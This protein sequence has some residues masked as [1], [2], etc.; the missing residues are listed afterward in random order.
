MDSFYASVEVRDNPSLK[1][2]PVG[3]G[4][5]TEKRGVLCTANY[6]A[7]KYGVKAALS[8]MYALKLCP[9]LILVKP[10]FEK[11]QEESLKIRE[12][13]K[14]YTELIEPLSLD[15][16]FLDVSDCKKCEGSATLIA[17]EI[18]AKIFDKTKL[19]ASA[20]IA[21]N[22]FLAKVASDWNKPNGQFVITPED[23]AEF[24]YKLPLK[25]IFGVGKV[26]ATKLHD[27]G[28]KTCGDIQKASIRELRDIV[29]S[30]GESLHKYSKGIDDR[31]V[32]TTRERKSI[33]VEHTF[34]ED[35][36]EVKEVAKKVEKIFAEL[37]YRL[38]NKNVGKNEIK[39]IFIKL[40][41]NDFQQTTVSDLN[42]SFEL[43]D[44]LQL[45]NRGFKRKEA[46]VRLLGLGVQLKTQ[47][48]VSKYQ[49]NFL[50]E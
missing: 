37:K 36:L 43:S 5:A 17:Q 27:Q 35:I 4:S 7:R 3:I 14:E 23:V 18:R 44:Y 30:F 2:K 39:S 29:G 45:V 12:I 25:K 50:N 9:D 47:K 33:S 32:C 19:T 21:P 13:F 34:K 31:E 24:V 1:G 41:F 8:T 16:A 48:K 11:Y 42:S 20:G 22:K 40:K 46:P 49:L 10:N 38:K 26:T 15:E 28:F 6:E